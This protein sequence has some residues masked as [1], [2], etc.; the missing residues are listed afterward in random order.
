MLPSCTHFIQ[1]SLVEGRTSICSRC[2]NP[3]T[4]TKKTLKNCGAKPHC[5]GCYKSIAPNKNDNDLD[6][7]IDSVLDTLLLNTIIE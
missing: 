3:F 6:K 2:A 1:E 4:I 5:E 7:K